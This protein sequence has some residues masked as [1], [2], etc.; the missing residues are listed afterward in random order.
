MLVRAA[1]LG[2][3]AAITPQTAEPV[4]SQN[5]SSAQPPPVGAWQDAPGYLRL[6]APSG[7]RAG[8][9][10]IFV[11]PLPLETLLARLAA[12]SSLLRPPG[13]W[14]P[15]ATQPTDAFGQTGGYDRSRLARLYSARR[16]LVARGPRGTA[17]HPTEAW[18]LVSPYPN[19]DMTRLETGTLLIVLDLQWRSPDNLRRDL[20]DTYK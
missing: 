14:S 7:V 15:T 17:G 13:A 16:A 19:R 18:A 5:A 8:A 11:S 3:T 20:R 6:F 12:D 9:Y 4:Q 2:L 1:L 10:H